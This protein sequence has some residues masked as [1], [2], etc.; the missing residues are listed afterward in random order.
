MD[1]LKDVRTAGKGKSSS[2]IK[3]MSVEGALNQTKII[4]S[5]AKYWESSKKTVLVVL[6]RVLDKFVIFH[7]WKMRFAF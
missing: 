3:N 2:Q 4:N 1:N 7:T 5:A 6:F